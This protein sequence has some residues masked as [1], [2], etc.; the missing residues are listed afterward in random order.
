VR[1]ASLLAVAVS[2]VVGAVCGVGGGLLL[3]NGPTYP[4]P[5]GIDAPL[6]NQPCQPNESLLVIGTGSNRSAVAAA[7][8]SV[9]GSGVRYLST[10]DSCDTAWNRA[11]HSPSRYAV[12]LGPFSTREACERRMTEG[13]QGHLVTLL[14]QGSTAPV[15]CLC[16]V[17]YAQMPV[18]RSTPTASTGDMIF[19]RALQDLLAHMGRIPVDHVTGVYDQDT[20]SAIEDFQQ[21]HSPPASG[22]VNSGTWHRLQQVGCPL[23]PS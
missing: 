12:Y 21:E 16:Y 1:P 10:R 13:I 2:A 20:Q 18:L 7:A 19:I 5:L 11:G 15:Q 9:S 4:D 14:T 23:Y 17:S 22:V 8:S 6:V 3:D